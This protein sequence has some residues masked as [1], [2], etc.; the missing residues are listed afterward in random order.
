MKKFMILVLAVCMTLSCA[1]AE[2]LSFG[3]DSDMDFSQV[4][5]ILSGLFGEMEPSPGMTGMFYTDVSGKQLL[6][7]NI[8]AVSAKEGNIG[9]FYTLFAE[10][11]EP[12]S[13]IRHICAIVSAISESHGTCEEI[14]SLSSID[15]TGN[16]V[17]RSILDDPDAFLSETVISFIW[18]H[19][20]ISVIGESINI[21]FYQ[22]G[23]DER[24]AAREK[25]AP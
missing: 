11:K 18:D 9:W 3:I 12:E 15:L 17:K 8:T 10:E 22:L 24:N 13:K 7:V 1:L 6:G 5:E 23:R 19:A 25:A 4:L 14:P 21:C 20:D 16:E 2:P